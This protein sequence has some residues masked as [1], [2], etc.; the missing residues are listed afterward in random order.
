LKY[1][2]SFAVLY[3]TKSL[4]CKIYFVDPAQ[5]APRKHRPRTKGTHLD[6]ITKAMGGRMPIV[7]EKGKRRPHDP[8]Q[9]AKFA[10]ESGVIIRD[11]IPILP[12]W[13]EYK[14]DNQHYKNF[15]GKLSV[16]A[17]LFIW[18]NCMSVYTSLTN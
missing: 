2:I 10:S 4:K 3:E 14:K 9:A 13:K 18:F 12:H 16:S 5:Q 17:L 6:K 7:V 1:L 15:V 8:V 11:K